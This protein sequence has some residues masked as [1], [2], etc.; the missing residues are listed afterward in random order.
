MARRRGRL[1]GG[2]ATSAWSRLAKARG[3]SPDAAGAGSP[4][5]RTTSVTASDRKSAKPRR[6]GAKRRTSGNSPQSSRLE[7]R[8]FAQ[9]IRAGLPT[10][11]RQVKLIPGRQFVHDLE[12]PPPWRLAVE[13]NGGVAKNLP[14][15]MSVAG[16]ERDCEKAAL[17]QA[18]GY[19]TIAVTSAMVRQ[20]R[21]LALIE[22]LLRR[23]GEPCESRTPS[24]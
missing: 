18:Q 8:L 15:H 17:V 12:F 4:G 9:I 16:Y 19:R 23:S 10:P 6:G 13:V 1:F 5:K 7:D 11:N 24:A 14:S 21:A 3:S 2:R 22:M 20:G